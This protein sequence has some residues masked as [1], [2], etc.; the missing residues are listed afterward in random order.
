MPCAKTRNYMPVKP[1]KQSIHWAELIADSVIAFTTTRHHPFDQKQS[2]APFAYFNLGQH[3]GDDVETVNKHRQCLTRLL[4][5]NTKIQ[6]L[7]QVHGADVVDV[8]QVISTPVVADAAITRE[9]HIALAI[10][11]AD[12][13]PILLATTTGHEI[14]AI[15]GGWRSLAGNII[16]NTVNKMSAS[17]TELCAWLGPCIGPTAFEVGDDVRQIFLALSPDFASAFIATGYQRYLANLPEIAKIQLQ[18]MGVS[19][20]NQLAH[21]T[22]NMP[23][24]Y[25]SYRRDKITGRMASI[26]CRQ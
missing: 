3:V 26:I 21:C 14:A 16:A 15:H 24:H 8:D 17:P 22:Y 19:D 13:L 20:I 25:Y 23:E 7:E 12:C 9:R 10:M 2:S 11:T 1:I 18:Q 5:Q 4:P 6:W